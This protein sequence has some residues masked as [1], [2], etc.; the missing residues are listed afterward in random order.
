VARWIRYEQQAAFRETLVDDWPEKVLPMFD[1]KAIR[2][3]W[4]AHVDGRDNHYKELWALFILAHWAR[5]HLTP[6]AAPESERRV[7]AIL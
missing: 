7:A 2:S 4:Q 5:H 1:R 6:V 3:L